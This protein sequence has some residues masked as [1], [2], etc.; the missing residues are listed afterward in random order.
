MRQKTAGMENYRSSLQLGW[1]KVGR[2]LVG[3]EGQE[4]PQSQLRVGMTKA[5]CAW[6]LCGGG[7]RYRAGGPAFG[8]GE[9]NR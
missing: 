8:S 6:I 5:L 7:Q 3:R 4:D 1:P 2:R 9:G